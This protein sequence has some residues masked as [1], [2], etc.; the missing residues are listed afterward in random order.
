MSY[1]L[2]PAFKVMWIST[3]RC[4]GDWGQPGQGDWG[5]VLHLTW[6]LRLWIEV[7]CFWLR[8]TKGTDLFLRAFKI[9]CQGKASCRASLAGHLNCS[10]NMRQKRRGT[11]KQIKWFHVN[12]H[13]RVKGCCKVAK[14]SDSF[15][16]CLGYFNFSRPRDNH[17]HSRYSVRGSVCRLL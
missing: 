16:G 14:R 7:R 11:L 10:M 2:I 9:L 13:T 5:Q 3:N 12:G 1:I 6:R 4:R 15:N 17:T 8:Q